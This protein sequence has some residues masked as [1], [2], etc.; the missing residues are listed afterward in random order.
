MIKHLLFIGLLFMVIATTVYSDCGIISGP[1]PPASTAGQPIV[2]GI[3]NPINS[4]MTHANINS[5]LNP[6]TFPGADIGAQINA[7]MA[8]S[9]G[10]TV[11]QIP[12][13][14]YTTGTTI[15]CPIAPTGSGQAAFIFQGAGMQSTVAV[16]QANPIGTII[17]YTGNGD[18]FNQVEPSFSSINTSGCRL[19]DMTLNG[20]N[21][22]ANAIGLHFGGT[23]FTEVT[24]VKFEN[25]GGAAIKVEN[26]SGMWTERYL[27][28]GTTSFEY[29]GVGIWFQNNT[30]A[31]GSFDHGSV[32]AWLNVDV[33]ATGMLTTNV[34]DAQGSTYTFNGN[35]AGNASTAGT[36]FTLNNSV[37][38]A[39]LID[40]TE[41][42]TPTGGKNCTRINISTAASTFFGDLMTPGSVGGPYTNVT[43]P[44]KFL[45]PYSVGQS[46]L[47]SA[48]IGMQKIAT[49]PHASQ[50]GGYPS[51]TNCGTSP[52]IDPDSTDTAG[53]IIMG[54]GTVPSCTLTFGNRFTRSVLCDA[55]SLGQPIWYY[56]TA[57]S[58]TIV[59]FVGG[60]CPSGNCQGQTLQYH[61]FGLGGL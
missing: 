12:A 50:V 55:T 27:I 48:N 7:A 36:L 22:G 14:V 41:C 54:S 17:N 3:V 42:Q 30:G 57:N 26:N 4:P 9:P 25:F 43:G 45:S 32:S 52:Q 39:T 10:G 58:G 16:S 5:T 21:H 6:L 2:A 56:T 28:Q 33:A 53:A 44:G 23:E 38:N 40:R 46:V 49:T 34:V 51:V 20:G 24:N 18:L 13:G 37:F 19:R 1:Y 60:N 15:Q 35:I 29:N 8:T 61:C 11:I 31:Q 47:S 59:T